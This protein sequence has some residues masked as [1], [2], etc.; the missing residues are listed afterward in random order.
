MVYDITEYHTDFFPW[1]LT[2]GACWITLLEVSITTKY[3]FGL[4]NFLF[5]VPLFSQLFSLLWIHLWIF[6]L[7]PN[8]SLSYF[9]LKKNH[10]TLYSL[11]KLLETLL[12][13]RLLTV[14]S[15]KFNGLFFLHT[16]KKD[17]RTLSTFCPLSIKLSAIVH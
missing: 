1:F 15:L 14:F 3:K 7:N 13:L 2:L 16:I 8:Q 4:N 11:Y 10:T 12:L 9:I 6:S 5:R 17:R